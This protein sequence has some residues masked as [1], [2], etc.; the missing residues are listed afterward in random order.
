MY[1]KVIPAAKKID[2]EIAA[3]AMFKSLLLGSSVING[4]GNQDANRNAHPVNISVV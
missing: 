3:K 4:F 2:K 1:V